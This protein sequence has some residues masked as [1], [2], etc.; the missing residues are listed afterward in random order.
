MAS[1]YTS[2]I[3]NSLTIYI[4]CSFC[5]SPL[6][7][8]CPPIAQWALITTQILEF[9]KQYTCSMISDMLFPLLEHCLSHSL[10]RS[11]Q[12]SPKCDFHKYS[13]ADSRDYFKQV[14][15]YVGWNPS[16]FLLL[17]LE[18]TGNWA[19]S[20]TTT[21]PQKQKIGGFLS[22]MA[23]EERRNKSFITCTL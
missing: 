8:T 6:H 11:S 17:L 7:I 22:W 14:R 18:K 1:L 9:S 21:I 12:V 23:L 13:R 20:T 10:Y 5:L 4:I 3:Q 2:N 15:P 19:Q 16:T